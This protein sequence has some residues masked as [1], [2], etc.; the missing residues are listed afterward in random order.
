VAAGL[1]YGGKAAIW[2]WWHWR[3]RQRAAEVDAEVGPLRV[4]VAQLEEATAATTTAGLRLRV[5]SSGVGP[6]GQVGPLSSG[7]TNTPGGTQAED[8]ADEMM[9]GGTGGS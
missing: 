2:G 4:R 9:T 1:W 3:R 5:P 6:G 7:L 8:V